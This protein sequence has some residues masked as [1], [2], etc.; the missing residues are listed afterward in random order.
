MLFRMHHKF[1]YR[2]IHYFCENFCGTRL[3]ILS[4][5]KK[6]YTEKPKEVVNI[7]VLHF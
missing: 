6:N 3:L 2:S 7:R 5:V 1:C 4:L